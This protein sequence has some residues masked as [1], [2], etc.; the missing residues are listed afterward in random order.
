MIYL[1]TLQSKSSR[2]H[3]SQ[4]F[5]VMM[6][7]S[8]AVRLKIV[9]EVLVSVLEDVRRYVIEYVGR[10]LQTKVGGSSVVP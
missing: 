4:V 8:N 6:F 5:L 1:L 10:A 2:K 3:E 9:G 7:F